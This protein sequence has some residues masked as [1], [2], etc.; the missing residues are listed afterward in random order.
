MKR[1]AGRNQNGIGAKHPC[2]RGESTDFFGYRMTIERSDQYD[3]LPLKKSFYLFYHLIIMASYLNR[4]KYHFQY[5]RFECKQQPFLQIGSWLEN[6]VS[7]FIKISIIGNT[8]IYLSI[9]LFIWHT[10]SNEYYE[11]GSRDMR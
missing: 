8:N 4:E 9:Y 10:P 1:I 7:A 3:F 2:V 11:P 6:H 5:T